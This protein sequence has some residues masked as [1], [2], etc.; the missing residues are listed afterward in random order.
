MSEGMKPNYAKPQHGQKSAS[1]LKKI[2]GVFKSEL[3]KG[4]EV[5]VSDEIKAGLASV[6]VG[7]ILKVYEN[8]TKDGR[9]YLS[10]NVKSLSKKNS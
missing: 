10:L 5:K 7:D 2:T 4:F 1:G 6:S 8:E 3:G 9:T